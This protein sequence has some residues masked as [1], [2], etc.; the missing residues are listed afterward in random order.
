MIVKQIIS[1]SRSG[2]RMEVT[3]KE[4]D[5]YQT[6]HLRQVGNVWRYFAGLN[7]NGKKVFSPITV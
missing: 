5:T 3:A 2:K 6:L 1:K 4:G 7:K